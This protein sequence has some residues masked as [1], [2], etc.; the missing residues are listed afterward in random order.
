MNLIVLNQ[1]LREG[2]KIIKTVNIYQASSMPGTILN[3]LH[4]SAYVILPTAL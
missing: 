2:N 1:P 4:L 3:G